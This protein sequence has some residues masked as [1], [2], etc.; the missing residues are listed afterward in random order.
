M[1]KGEKYKSKGKTSV[2]EVSEKTLRHRHAC[3]SALLSLAFLI[4]NP[5]EKKS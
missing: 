4:I 2:N 3:Y 1:K 5:S